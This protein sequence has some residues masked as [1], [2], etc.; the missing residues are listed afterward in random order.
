[1][2]QDKSLTRVNASYGVRALTIEGYEIH[3]GETHGPDCAR[4]FAYIED[5]PEGAQSLT[6]QVKGTYLHGLFSNDLFRKTFLTGIGLDSGTG[7]YESDVEQ[8]LDALA[9]HIEG[10]LDVDQMLGVA[11]YKA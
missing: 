6:G 9:A 5:R 4:P 3:I 2:S 10:H 11:G 7:N 1:M 8:T